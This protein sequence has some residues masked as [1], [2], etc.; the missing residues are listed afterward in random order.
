MLTLSQLLEIAAR[1]S[2][3]SNQP[4]KFWVDANG[5]KHSI[6]GSVSANIVGGFAKVPG[7]K[8]RKYFDGEAIYYK[9]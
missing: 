7:S 6:T 5:A 9:V 8:S 4:R 2:A 1:G 3:N